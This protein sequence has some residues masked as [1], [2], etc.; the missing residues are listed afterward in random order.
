MVMASYYILKAKLE[1]RPLVLTSAVRLV[2]AAFQNKL[3]A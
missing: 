1:L 2:I 3:A